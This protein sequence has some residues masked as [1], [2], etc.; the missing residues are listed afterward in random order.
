MFMRNV[1]VVPWDRLIAWHT[2]TS[3]VHH[4]VGGRV[5]SS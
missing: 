4:C 5:D 3:K 2:G 1:V